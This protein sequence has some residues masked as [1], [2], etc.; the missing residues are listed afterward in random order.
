MGE[1]CESVSSFG[2]LKHFKRSEKPAAA[3]EAK[4]C[5]DC[6][7][8]AQCAYSAK[9]IY[10]GRLAQ[11]DIGWP[12]DV[13]TPEPSVETVT[14]ALENGP[15]GRCVYECDND[16]VDHQVVSMQFAGGKTAV[17]TMTAF[18]QA[19]NRKTRI[20]GTRGEL[21]GDGENIQVFDFL[22]DKTRTIPTAM[23]DD[24]AMGGHGGGDYGLMDHFVAAVAA[25]DPARI[26]SGPDES[27]ETHRMVFAAERARHEH[28]VVDL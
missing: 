11:G 25:K 3:G 2:A 13:L 28:R 22:T 7:Y 16:V 9:K 20:F 14:A 10:L 6:A 19:A 4:R 26:L 5:L 1:S 27:L 23:D 15:Y 8:E 21:Y 17:F 12:V 24:T 18:N